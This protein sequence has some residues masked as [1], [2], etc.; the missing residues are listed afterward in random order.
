ML[1]K[2]SIARYTNMIVASFFSSA[3]N[4]HELLGTDQKQAHE[5]HVSTH[6]A[7][8]SSAILPCQ[9]VSFHNMIH[10]PKSTNLSGK[11][12][13]QCKFVFHSQ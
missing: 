8:L 12:I 13:F 3:S 11:K 9:G 2:N 10:L 5:T 4:D 6:N 7:N 1:R